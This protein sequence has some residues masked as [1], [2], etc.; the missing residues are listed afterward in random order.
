MI[1][2]LNTLYLFVILFYYFLY[3]LI[4]NFC[5]NL[6][7]EKNNFFDIQ[8]FNIILILNIF[9][10]VSFFKINILYLL[11]LFLIL[12]LFN[13]IFIKSKSI[14]LINNLPMYLQFLFY[15]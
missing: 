6:I 1:E 5:I 7:T 4:I 2:I 3:P 15:F 13:L 9:I 11:I 10:I 8:I 14:R 12:S